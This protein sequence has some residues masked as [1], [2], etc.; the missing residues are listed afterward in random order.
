MGGGYT[1]SSFVV[2]DWMVKACFLR[3][4]L[5]GVRA[6]VSADRLGLFPRSQIVWK[7]QALCA[8]FT[9]Y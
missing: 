1:S 5:S 7:T 4:V 8:N 6:K 2:Y 3:T 9:T